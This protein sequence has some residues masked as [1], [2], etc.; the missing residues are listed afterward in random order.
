[1]ETKDIRVKPE[2]DIDVEELNRLLRKDCIKSI[3]DD[4]RVVSE[5]Y[6]TDYDAGRG[7]E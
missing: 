5:R 3:L 6:V 4:S 2:I 7:A 1:M